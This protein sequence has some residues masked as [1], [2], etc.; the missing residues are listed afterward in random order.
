MRMYKKDFR[1]VFGM[2]FEVMSDRL[3]ESMDS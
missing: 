1:S 3:D 2:S